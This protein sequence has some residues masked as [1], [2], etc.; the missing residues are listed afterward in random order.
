MKKYITQLLADLQDAHRP[1]K[2]WSE[3]NDTTTFEQHIEE[4][5]RFLNYEDEPTGPTFGEACNV[6]KQVFPPAERL[7]PHQIEILNSAIKKLLWTWNI[8]VELPD[9]LTLKKVYFF[10]VEMFDTQVMIV[11]S[12]MIG[13]DFCESDFDLCPFGEA[14]CTCKKDYEE[15]EAKDKIYDEQV[16]FFVEDLDKKLSPTNEKMKV[17]LSDEVVEINETDTQPILTLAEWLDISMEDFPDDFPLWEKRANEIS[18]IVMRLWH[19][20]DEMVSIL[21]A[22]DWDKRFNT[23]KSHLK[24]KVWLDGNETLYFL[25]IPLE[26]KS[27]LQSPLDSMDFDLEFDPDGDLPF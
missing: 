8:T 20:T 17:I 6:D 26:D 7:Q 10:Y 5:E 1:E 15:R 2:D 13:V 23:L 21:N 12:G 3:D 25:P 18:K 27:E 24:N 19:P 16:R 4:V 22:L 14:H 9:T 11:D